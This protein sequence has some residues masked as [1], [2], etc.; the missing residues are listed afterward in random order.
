MPTS[1]SKLQDKGKSVGTARMGKLYTFKYIATEE[2]TPYF[3]MYPT[4]IIIRKIVGGFTGINF[5]YI[6][7]DKRVI[8]L[9]KLSGLFTKQ[10]GQKLFKFKEFR[11]LSGQ[12]AYRAALVCIRNYRFKNIRS[13]LVQ[14][15]DSIWDE[16]IN[17]C[18]EMFVRVNPI[19]KSR[20]LLKSEL[21]WRNSLKQI[22]GNS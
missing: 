2:M 4:T 9:K 1:I 15:D 14:V 7:H 19:T 11:V 12:R 10:S 16:T 21:V 3:D 17:R 18:D 13:P 20:S 8:L 22:R 6:G 5:N